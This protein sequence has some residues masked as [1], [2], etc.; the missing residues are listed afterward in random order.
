VH[1]RHGDFKDICEENVLEKQCFTALTAWKRNVEEMQAELKER[2]G[3]DVTYVAVTSDEKDQEWWNEV[4]SYGWTRVD[5]AKLG[6]GA[7]FAG[8]GRW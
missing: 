6:T 2:K 7:R 1:I 5:H 4:A 3:L 8:R